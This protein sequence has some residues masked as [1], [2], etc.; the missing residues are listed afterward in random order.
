MA[1]RFA[2]FLAPWAFAVAGVAGA[3]ALHLWGE[4]RSRDEGEVPRAPAPPEVVRVGHSLNIT[5]APAILGIADGT[6]ERALGGIRVEPYIFS[7]GPS[8]VEALFAGS[9]DI[10]YLGPNPAVNAHLRSGG[11]AVRVVA[12]C[13]SGGASLVVRGDLPAGGTLAVPQRG[14]SQDV[15]ARAWARGLGLHPR[16]VAVSNPDQLSLF[17]KREVDAAWTVEPWVSRLVL[18][19]GGRVLVDERTL[20]PGGEF[21]TTLVVVNRRFL[22]AHP[23]VVKRWLRAHVELVRRMEERPAE[24]RRELNRHLERLAGKGLREDVLADAFSRLRL[25]WDPV[26]GSIEECARRAFDEGY[27][28]RERPDLTGL[29]DLG[30][31]NEVL[32][33]LSLPPVGR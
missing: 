20:W 1:R 31:L 28:G 10:A 14:N 22:Q 17:H 15:A 21:A 26:A 24:T 29:L 4:S 7:A 27:L 5:H 23:E 18:E 33:E 2:L 19:A 25:T 32:A 11:K 12:G 13:A 6:F 9:V 30:P 16:I 8:V 3:W